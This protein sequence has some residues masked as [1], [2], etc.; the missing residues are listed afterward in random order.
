MNDMNIEIRSIEDIAPYE[1]NP[2]DNDAAVGAVAESIRTFGFRQPIVVDDSGVIVCGHTRY[3]AA[4]QL[5]LKRVPVHV[6]TDLTVVVVGCHGSWVTL[7]RWG[8]DDGG[9][10]WFH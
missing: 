2:R 7:T 5:E 8:H 1:A 6:A 9:G 4:Q 3:K 10:R